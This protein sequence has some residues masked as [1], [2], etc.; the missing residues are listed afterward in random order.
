MLSMAS[1]SHTLPYTCTGIIALVSFV[2]SFSILSGSIVK[3]SSLISQKTGFSPFLTMACVVEAK[4]NGV[5][6]TSPSIF[7]D[8]NAS[9]NA[10]CPFTV[11]TI[12]ISSMNLLKVFSSSLCT[13]PILV[14][15]AL[16]HI[17]ST[18]S[19][20][21][22]LG[23]NVAFVTNIFFSSFIRLLIYR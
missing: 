16:S 18:Y 15:Q 17:L 20:N 2:I 19:R 5:V 4:V 8:C 7:R 11:R 22:S 12:S 23:G 21:S 13:S 6:I 1:T 14:S 9:S 3:S 10:R